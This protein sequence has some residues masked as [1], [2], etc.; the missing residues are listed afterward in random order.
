MMQL[1]QFT[2]QVLWKRKYSIRKQLIS[3]KTVQDQRLKYAKGKTV[4][5]SLQFGVQ[6]IMKLPVLNQPTF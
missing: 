1:K 3:V 2:L 6:Q 4:T 5:F